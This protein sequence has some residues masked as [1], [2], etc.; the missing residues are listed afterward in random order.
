[1]FKQLLYLAQWFIRARF[2]GRRAPLQTVLFITDKCNLRCK[3]CSVYGSAGYRQ[4]SFDDILEEYLN[5]EN[6]DRKASYRIVYPPDPEE[7]AAGL[8]EKGRELS[9]KGDYESAISSF[10]AVPGESDYSLRARAERGYAEYYAGK[11]EAALADLTGIVREGKGDATVYAAV[12][13]ILYAENRKEE[14]EEYVREFSA[15]KTDDLSEL[16]K[17]LNL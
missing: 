7:L 10:S 3:H 8:Y 14:A 12:I 1:M 9:E 6:E 17:K 16:Y 2:F 4:R 11:T 15:S 13:R 5:G